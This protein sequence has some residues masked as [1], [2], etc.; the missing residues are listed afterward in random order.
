[1][2]PL[3]HPYGL[4][5]CPLPNEAQARLQ[6][7]WSAC[8]R[9]QALILCVLGL[10]T[11]L[12]G[13]AEAAP[14]TVGLIFEAAAVPHPVPFMRFADVLVESLAASP[15][16]EALVLHPESPLL[17]AAGVNWPQPERQ[18]WLT[19]AESLQNLLMATELDD[20]LVL[21]PLPATTNDV[22]ILW[23]RQG[24]PEI[25][26]LHL[27]EPG[28]GDK[29]YQAL[30][31][32]LIAK[33]Q[34]GPDKAPIAS[35][36]NTQGLVEP[37][38]ETDSRP[39][40]EATASAIP[41]A[42]A[43]S[44]PARTPESTQPV[45]AGE[46]RLTPPALATTAPPQAQAEE[47]KPKAELSQPAGGAEQPQKEIAKPETEPKEPAIHVPAGKEQTHASLEP[48]KEF[49][50]LTAAEKYLKEGDYKKTEAMLIKAKEA[51]EPYV[52][53]CLLWAKLEQ[54]RRNPQAE[55]L[56][57]QR[58]LEQDDQLPA[59]HLRLAELFREEGLWRKS[60]EEY[61]K[62]LAQEPKNL[63]AYL[64]LSAIYARQGQPRRA[65][66]ILTEA[67]KHYPR[68]ANLYLRI[69]DLYASRQAWAEAENA[70]DRA[71]RLSEG[72][73]RAEALDRLGDL[74]IAAGREREG[75]I[76][77]AEAAKLRLADGNSLSEKRYRQI[78]Q[79]ADEALQKAAQ[80]AYEALSAYMTTQNV[81]RPEVWQ[82]FKEFSIQA[83]DVLEFLNNV[84]PPNTLKKEHLERKLA[85]A[86]AAEAALAG[87]EYVDLGKIERL[88][89][90]KRLY[91]E[92]RETIQK[93]QQALLVP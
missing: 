11:A 84:P 93:L 9:S 58:A 85:Y 32:Q 60:I 38:T 23:L 72:P 35:H 90:Y 2:S 16:W 43:I 45:P 8:R 14:R 66:E 18:D 63:Y 80:R 48:E 71:A 4:H 22:E 78:M 64:G 81:F 47:S 51:G 57:L 86:L 27:S 6:A 26:R 79:A 3:R 40:A 69:G 49:E 1:M 29:A 70:Y 44:S 41:A 30:A 65:A 75:F 82:A 25:R 52:S 19:V 7:K 54:A 21:R 28:A 17:R 53:I 39:P 37:S 83:Q 88:E 92:A 59:V 89:D 87:L 61:Q 12:N 76:C 91:A 13:R 34:E 36:T 10:W 56:W 73:R 5:R 68:E 20:L 42:P 24:Q 67:L 50:Y 46:Q 77:Y 31:Q 33:L 62:V 74:Y 15:H 55:R